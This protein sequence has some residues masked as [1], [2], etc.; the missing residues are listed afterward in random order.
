[1]SALHLPFIPLISYKT[2]SNNLHVYV[3]LTLAIYNTQA[4]LPSNN[5][6]VYVGLTLAP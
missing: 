3:R 2:P 4:I 1:M 5:L 6:H